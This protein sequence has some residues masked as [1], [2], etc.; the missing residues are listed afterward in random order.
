MNNKEEDG[1]VRERLDRTFA[2]VEWVNSYPHYTLKNLPIIDSDHGPILLN[3]KHQYPFSKMPFRFELM[4]LNH[5]TCKDMIYQAWRLHTKG[6]R[7]T[8]L[9]NKLLNVRKEAIN[10]NKL[11]F[12][13]VDSEIKRKLADLQEI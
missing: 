8:Q 10:W 9:N 4:W 13:K 2:N 7:A 12:G 6:S 3:F 11:D 1:F 5:P